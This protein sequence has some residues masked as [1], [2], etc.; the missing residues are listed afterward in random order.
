MHCRYV[1]EVAAIVG[2]C[3]GLERTQYFRIFHKH[4]ILSV[5]ENQR[6]QSKRLLSLKQVC[7]YLL[8]DANFISNSLRIQVCVLNSLD[9]Y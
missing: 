8:M 2:L 6:S 1:G 4:I 5:L 3:S 9:L 7:V